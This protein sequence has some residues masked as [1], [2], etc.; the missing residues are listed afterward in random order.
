MPLKTL[1]RN[2]TVIPA[3]GYFTLLTKNLACIKWVKLA[4]PLTRYE[5]DVMEAIMSS[6]LMK[7]KAEKNAFKKLVKHTSTFLKTHPGYKI[8]RTEVVKNAAGDFLKVAIYGEPLT[9]T[10]SQHIDLKALL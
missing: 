6:D 4:T 9:R 3:Q 8:T 1:A 7:Q 5:P 10:H 2:S